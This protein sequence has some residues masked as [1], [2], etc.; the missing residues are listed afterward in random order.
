[1]L[2][3]QQKFRSQQSLSLMTAVLKKKLESPGRPLGKQLSRFAC[4]RQLLTHLK[5]QRN[6]NN[7]NQ[8]VKPFGSV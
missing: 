2:S 5:N 7:N 3:W 4:L 1:M 6:Y 8:F